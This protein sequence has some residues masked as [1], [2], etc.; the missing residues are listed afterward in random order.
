M[1]PT[2]PAGPR[3]KALG[4]SPQSWPERFRSNW[5]LVTI[6]A[7]WL[8]ANVVLLWPEDQTDREYYDAYIVMWRGIEDFRSGK[9]APELW[10]EFSQEKL[11]ELRSILAD[12]EDDA[13]P[14]EPDKQHLLWAGRDYLVPILEGK[15]VVDDAKLREHMD[16]ARRKLLR[17]GFDVEPFTRPAAEE[18]AQDGQ[19][20][21]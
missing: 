16:L 18:V 12:L 13:S 1:S 21:G 10:D 19:T 9:S 8:L 14:A 4:R 2:S 15:A 6:G 17:E 11:A 7:L 20:A 3:G 5:P